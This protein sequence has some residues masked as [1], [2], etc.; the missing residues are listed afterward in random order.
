MYSAVDLQIVDELD[1]PQLG[2]IISAEYATRSRQTLGPKI[3]AATG[4]LVDPITWRLDPSLRWMTAHDGGLKPIYRRLLDG[5]RF[6]K[7]SIAW[8]DRSP[9]LLERFVVEVLEFQ[10][11][12]LDTSRSPQDQELFPGMLPESIGRS[13]P[14][15]LFSPTVLVRDF[16]SLADQR[17][18]WDATPS[19]FRGLPVDLT[20]AIAPRFLGE[21]GVVA[22]VEAFLTGN[23]RLWLFLPGFRGLLRTRVGV[24]LASRIRP[25][26]R[27]FLERAP[28]GILG[29]GHH[30]SLLSLDGVD[31][32]AF[33]LHLEG[34][35]EQ[36][37]MGRPALPYA[38]VT[39][40]HGLASYDEVCGVVRDQ[41]AIGFAHWFCPEPICVKL[42]E[43]LGA[44]RYVREM[45]QTTPTK[46]GLQAAPIAH[47]QQRRH[48][49]RARIWELERIGQLS[50]ATLLRELRAEAHR[51]PFLKAKAD[52]E[53]W[54]DA[55]A[56]APVRTAR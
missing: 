7:D 35:A 38:Y 47:A 34:G 13:R 39:A 8:R 25:A 37:A 32:I 5:F 30:L 19:T 52:L 9:D 54:L 18:L 36:K 24:R 41:D 55:F 2:W 33:G 27:R 1:D 40:A 21:D 11:S 46:N 4:L 14:D 16:E 31:A 42:F 22:E 10:E 26:V 29:A 3:K 28:V 49:L 6:P 50:E 53:A 44:A 23:R 17:A 20:L 15:R 12:Q 45:F 43:E 48:G 51:T 56:T